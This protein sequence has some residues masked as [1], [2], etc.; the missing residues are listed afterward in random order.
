MKLSYRQ[1]AQRWTEAS[2]I[3]N[4]RL[5]AMVFG[6]VGRE[7]IQFNDD[8]CWTG[9]P[10]AAHGR[11]RDVDVD[12]PS[13]LA[14]M[15]AALE[16]G[17]HAGATAAQQQVQLGWSQAYQ[18]LGNLFLITDDHDPATYMRQL[19]LQTATVTSQWS[20]ESRTV[21]QRVWISAVDGTLTVERVVV[22]GK[23]MTGNVLLE[24][25]HPVLRRSTSP[26][27][28]SL[29]L[30]MPSDLQNR[31]PRAEDI[32]YNNSRGA[33]L[34]AVV[35][36]DLSHDGA[37][38]DSLAFTNARRVVIRLTTDTDFQGGR[39]APHGD[40][41]LLLSAASARLDAAATVGVGESLRRHVADYSA[42][43]NRTSLELGESI[44]DV[45]LP[46]L[47]AQTQESG[48]DRRLA[49]VM[50]AYGRYLTIAGSRRGSRPLN[51]QGI[52]NDNTLPPWRSN[53]TTNINLEMNY[54]PTEAVNLSEC[55]DALL[56]W[57]EDLAESGR[58]TARELYGMPGWVA[59][60]NSDVW[61]FSVPVGDGNFD[62]VWS[63]W[64]LA[65][66]W[67]CRHVWERW[68]FSRDRRELA[69]RCWPLLRG[70]AEF[71]LAWM[72]EI[73]PGELGTSPSTS[74][75]NHFVLPD[76]SVTGLTVSTTS[77]IAML[78]DHLSNC[79]AA[80]RE[81]GIEDDFTH[82]VDQ[83]LDA[84]PAENLTPDC[85]IAEWRDHVEDAEPGH[86]HQSHLYGVMPGESI[87][88]W[89]DHELAAG[90]L[91]TLEARGRHTTG[92]SLAWRIGI[93]A[94]LRDAEGA[95]AS[96]LDFFAP[97]NNPDN[98]GPTGPAGL[99]SNLFCAHPPFQID[100][101][102][103]VTAAVLEMVVQSHGGRIA[104]LPALPRA[105][106]DGEIRG[107]RVRGGGNLDMLW[108]DG[109][110]LHAEL[111][112]PA[113]RQFV[114]EIKGS[115]VDVVIPAGGVAVLS[116][117]G[118]RADVKTISHDCALAEHNTGLQ[119]SIH[120]APRPYLHPIRS[121]AGTIVTEAE[122][123]DH[124]H[125]LG[126][127][128][129][130]SDVNG[131]NF[132]GGSTYTA[133]NGPLLLANHGM[134]LPRDW[135]S[136]QDE[137]TGSVTWLSKDGSELAAEQRR[138]RYFPN[139]S[140]GSWGLSLSSLIVP[141]LGVQRLD[142]SSSALKGRQG[143]G[144][145]GIFWRFPHGSGVPL[146]LSTAGSG[147]GAAHGSL[148]PWLSV[149]MLIHGS[150]VSVVLAQE[151]E[152]LLPWFIRA[153][154]YLGAGPAVAWTDPVVV[155]DKNPLKLA[156]HAIIHDGP[157]STHA[158]AL[159]ILGRHPLT[160]PAHS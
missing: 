129:A 81:L 157:I 20:T 146:V 100:G 84:L 86:R 97:I 119:Q 141:A 112:A 6:D 114:V 89:R 113:G 99:Y 29:V 88:P 71:L 90:A 64:P 38:V 24:S 12:G 72:V 110:V 148:S 132:W 95:H 158:Q 57:L 82:A 135:Q 80:A 147:A 58:I 124:R 68:E 41:E 91:R 87:L 137:A 23:A 47:L 4:G 65:G 32:V 49:A 92:W 130:F 133:A 104:L 34:T 26:Q 55:H 76:G 16:A 131:T 13:A 108:R 54:W 127:S 140:N 145:G 40:D 25:P 153:E 111:R 9:S 142:V 28:E 123:E 18:P 15:R 85:L 50:F 7:R 45:L 42:L 94:R 73:G 118:L 19:D 159:E 144:Y 14:Q 116:D 101:N 8:T 59:H 125:H 1:P 143:A 102:F 75:E 10:A 31:R 93:R 62:P 136:T 126:L 63:M 52:W 79:S 39:V 2:P 37:D 35:A 17:N 115:P 44:D 33:S 53:L 70:S 48:D 105:W 11:L 67:L 156:L 51:L 22:T 98:P 30:R 43:F 83:A 96:L 21:R 152:H 107:V 74:P 154:E 106:S 69:E 155:D 121:K 151:P 134:Q 36:V 56:D 120:L 109:R 78:R 61:G 117:D 3:G 103:G 122:P 150:A 60:H 160:S 5:G 66:A 27:R 46:D 77:D 139:I 138:I 149:S 128:I